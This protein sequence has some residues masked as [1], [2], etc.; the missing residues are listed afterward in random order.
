ME[1]T[2]SQKT[3]ISE[4]RALKRA[5]NAILLCHNYQRPEI[6]EIAD[7]IGDSLELCRKAK[8]SKAKVIVF[9]GVYFMAESAAILNPEMKVI[10]PSLG[11]GCALADMITVQALKAKKKKYPD[12]AVVCY[13]N[14]TAAVKAEAD[15]CCTSSSAVAVVRAMPSKRILFVPD[16]NLA[17][18]VAAQVP[19]KEIIPWEGFCPIHQRLTAEQL[20]LAKASYP[21]AK[22]IAHPECIDEVR[23]MADFVTSTSGMMKIAKESD[24]DEFIC[25]TECGMVSRMQ[26]EMPNKKFHTLCSVCFSMKKNTLENILECL[27][28][29]QFEIKI[30]EN[31]RI[32]AFNAFEKMFAISEKSPKA[33]SAK[34]KSSCS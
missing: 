14:S 8:D 5:K 25:T 13:V 28:A 34:L 26:K 27:K 7:F 11:A 15:A 31:I 10:I 3:L 23:E 9:C 33:K 18:F 30:P 22:V 2:N 1:L 16:K 21:K 20:L 29:E 12:A 32:K 6:Y 4:I 17:R 19:E 24:A